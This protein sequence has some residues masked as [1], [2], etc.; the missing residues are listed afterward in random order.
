M[1]SFLLLLLATTCAFAIPSQ[2]DALNT[3]KREALNAYNA[4]QRT[5]DKAQF[6]AA[7]NGLQ[8]V[9]QK[10]VA[11]NQAAMS[12]LRPGNYPA[13]VKSTQARQS[14]DK[15]MVDISRTLNSANQSLGNFILP[16]EVSPESIR[17]VDR[18]IREIDQAIEGHH[19]ACLNIR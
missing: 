8:A 18:Y 13:D 14:W 2:R 5:K 1:R 6:I 16:T 9:G 4:A 15:K 17:S 3:A 12:S 10:V 7:A 11:A 19:A